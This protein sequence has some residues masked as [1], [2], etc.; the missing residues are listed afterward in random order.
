ME[1]FFGILK[2]RISGQVFTGELNGKINY[3]V[4]Y[5]TIIIYM[6]LSVYACFYFCAREYE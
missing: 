1:L 4:F 3:H 5:L 6:C 2:P